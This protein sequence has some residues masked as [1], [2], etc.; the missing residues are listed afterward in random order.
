MSDLMNF[1]AL[2]VVILYIIN[3]ISMSSLLFFEKKPS[4]VTLAWLMVFIFIP[5]LG[6]IFYF[7]FGSTTK[8]KMLSKKYT[9]K[10]IE[11]QYDKVLW[12][13]YKKI[14]QD[15]IEF[16]DDKV[17]NYKDIILMNSS[18]AESI[19][20]QDNTV[21]ILVNANEK[22]AAL[23]KDIENAKESINVLYFIIKGKDKSGKMFISLLAKKARQGVEVRL[24]YDS[25]G[26]LKT[27]YSD[28]KPLIDAGG[29]VYKYLPS[30]I[31]TCVEANYRMHRKMVIIDGVTAYTGGINIG[32]DYLGLD[33]RI[34]PWRD[35]SIKVTGS[36]VQ[37]IQL[38][39]VYDWLYIDMQLNPKKAFKSKI[40][41]PI[42]QEMY[43]KNSINEG[44]SGVQIISSG[45]D[46]DF[47]IVKDQ[48]I[49]LISSAKDYLYI[50][51]PYFVPDETLLNVLRIAAHSGVDI[52]VMIPGI[53]DK[54]FVYY[55]TLSYIEYL[56][57]NGIRVYTHKGFV[58]AKTFVLDDVITSIGTAN[59]DMRSFDLDYE[60]NAVIYDTDF[61]K[62]SR[63]I[64]LN[65]VND[66]EEIFLDDYKKRSRLQKAKESFFRI[67]AP[68]T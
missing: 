11:V 54:K 44:K 59:L 28:F 19:Y 56:L 39:F 49:K 64:F 35:T 30:I 33:K 15:K 40:I 47:S 23:F 58:H 3:L 12:D 13:N 48:Y 22:Y 10:A 42:H 25:L 52:R 68:L 67:V 26:C 29:M 65:D 46:C 9:E 21:K 50:Q 43:F 8:L 37:S 38:R 60:L 31:K 32:D 4:S 1:W 17:D 41:D 55:I 57:E 16:N 63:E 5:I 51:T 24:I 27:T 62:E 66:C 2:V 61:A 20:T 6:F 18:N 45:P 36:A 7:F 34:T 53:P 14:D